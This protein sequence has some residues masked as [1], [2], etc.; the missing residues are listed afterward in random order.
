MSILQENFE[1]KIIYAGHL[2]EVEDHTYNYGFRSVYIGNKW[3]YPDFSCLKG[4]LG[5]RPSHKAYIQV[6]NKYIVAALLTCYV[7][8]DHVRVYDDRFDKIIRIVHKLYRMPMGAL[9]VTFT[10]NNP[11]VL[12]LTEP[13]RLSSFSWSDI[14]DFR[15]V[16]QFHGNGYFAR[17]PQAIKTMN[18]YM[19]R[20]LN[21]DVDNDILNQ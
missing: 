14:I 20:L 4:L 16:P 7:N 19:E 5:F 15:M 12:K 2:Y 11:C 3:Y 6:L 18:R 13:S 10:L 21:Y 1:P 8:A 9:D 17:K